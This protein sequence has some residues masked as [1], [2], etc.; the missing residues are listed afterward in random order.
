MKLGLIKESDMNMY[1]KF[2]SL[3]G[4][5]LVIAAAVCTFTSC[6]SGDDSDPAPVATIKSDGGG[7]ATLM[8]LTLD[9][10]TRSGK[11]KVTGLSGGNNFTATG[12]YEVDA[13]GTKVTLK[14]AKI[15]PAAFAAIE[16]M[17]NGDHPIN[18]SK[19]VMIAG[20]TF[21]L[22]DLFAKM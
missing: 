10:T 8:V 21:D 1:K 7:D 12:D 16:S 2:F 20:F 3:F 22:T 19:K 6:K 13:A 9:K 11:C 15:T 14:N 17:I 18:A 5:A 4:A